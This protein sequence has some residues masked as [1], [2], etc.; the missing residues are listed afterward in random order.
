MGDDATTLSK[1]GVDVSEKVSFKVWSSDE[2]RD[3]KV[4]EWAEGS[5]FYRVDAINRVS[6]IEM[7]PMVADMDMNMNPGDRV[8]VKLVNVLGQEVNLDNELSKREVLFNVYDDGTVD[9]VL[10]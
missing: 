8:L 10:K 6:S 1:E 3:F 5:S 4:K 2:V 9:K 7:Y